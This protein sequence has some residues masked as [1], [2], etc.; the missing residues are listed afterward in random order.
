M[1]GWSNAGA[2]RRSSGRGT[3]VGMRSLRVWIKHAVAST[4]EAFSL[5]MHRP[6]RMPLFDFSCSETCVM[7]WTATCDAK[8]G[9]NST[10]SFDIDERLGVAAF[11]G[12]VDNSIADD[13][14]KVETGFDLPLR[15]AGFAAARSPAL[16]SIPL[17]HFDAMRFRVRGDGRPYLCSL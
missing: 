4:R 2:V 15:Y 13:Q 10:S 16:P 8:F 1:G 11:S 12:V 7:T 17:D 6:V 3:A 9:G 14:V 5:D